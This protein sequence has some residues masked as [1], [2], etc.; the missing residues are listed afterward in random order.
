MFYLISS[1]KSRLGTVLMLTHAHVFVLSLDNRE[2]HIELHTA[3]RLLLF[4]YQRRPVFPV[5]L[6]FD[7]VFKNVK[8]VFIL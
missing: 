5:H 6:K 1:S 3:G 4:S 8:N 2:L 7:S